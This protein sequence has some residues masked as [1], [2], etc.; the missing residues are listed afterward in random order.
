MSFSVEFYE[1][2]RDAAASDAIQFLADP[3]KTGRD[4][5]ATLP[6]NYPINAVYPYSLGTAQA[7]IAR[8]L[9]TLG[10]P[11]HGPDRFDCEWALTHPFEDDDRWFEDAGVAS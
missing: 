9:D 5:A 3:T 7:I 6:D 4:Y 1:R 11:E 8:L 10:Y 2:R